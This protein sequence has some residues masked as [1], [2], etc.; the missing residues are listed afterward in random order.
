VQ[1]RIHLAQA[2]DVDPGQSRTNLIRR[3]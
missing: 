1:T 2:N 3:T